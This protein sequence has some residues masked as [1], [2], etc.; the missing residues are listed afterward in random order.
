MSCWTVSTGN[1]IVMHDCRSDSLEAIR[2]TEILDF[3]Y[4]QNSEIDALKMHITTEGIRSEMAVVGPLGN[5]VAN[6]LNYARGA[7]NWRLLCRLA[8]RL[9]KDHNSSNRRDFLA[10]ERRQ[11]SKE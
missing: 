5:C 9:F 1:V 7:E 11:V 6:H 3:G 8:R 10:T 2:G 4:P